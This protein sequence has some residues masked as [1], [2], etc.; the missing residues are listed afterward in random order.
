M[1]AVKIYLRISYSNGMKML[2]ELQIQRN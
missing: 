1:Q 2:I